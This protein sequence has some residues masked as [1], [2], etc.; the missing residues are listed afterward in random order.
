MFAYKV[1]PFVSQKSAYVLT[2]QY[3]FSKI[4]EQSLLALNNN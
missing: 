4:A 1:N 3:I 2:K